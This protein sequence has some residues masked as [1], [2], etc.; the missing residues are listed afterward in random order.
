MPH[1]KYA[2][3]VGSKNFHN[4]KNEKS[5]KML[6]NM[7][8]PSLVSWL[9]LYLCWGTTLTCGF[10]LLTVFVCLHLGVSEA[11]EGQR[12]SHDVLWQFWRFPGHLRLGNPG[13]EGRRHG[14]TGGNQ[15][16]QHCVEPKQHQPHL[17]RLPDLPHRLKPL[18]HNIRVDNIPDLLKTFTAIKCVFCK[19]IKTSRFNKEW[20]NSGTA[21]LK[22]ISLLFS[23][24]T[25]T[26][27]SVY[28]KLLMCIFQNT[29]S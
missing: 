7:A 8:Q 4:V 24:L 6:R 11:Y 5:S 21:A 19:S 17:H 2:D 13:A 15:I 27:N 10:V 18:I 25:L 16:Q 3:I 23:V 22:T 20:L 28:F 12:Q 1:L 14:V 29:P 26:T 9:S